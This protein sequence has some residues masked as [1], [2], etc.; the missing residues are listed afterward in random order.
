MNMRTVVKFILLAEAFAVT[1]FGLGWWIVP[2]V[3][4]V[5]GLVSRD[6]RKARFAAFAAATGWA[7]LLLL[8]VAR[9][10]VAVM[11]SQLAGVMKLPAI[12]LYVLTLI[13]PA[14]L[15][16]GA[17]TLTPSVRKGAD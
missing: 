6:V 15:A 14:L 7:S 9:G 8:D 10:P 4:A 1:T 13:F 17:A 11:G 12:A 16:W 5:W 3:A 2:V